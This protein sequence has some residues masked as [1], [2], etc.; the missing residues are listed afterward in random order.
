M[1]LNII[2]IITLQ[3]Q[4]SDFFIMCGECCDVSNW[5]QLLVCIRWVDLKLQAPEEVIGTYV[6]SYIKSNTIVAIIKDTLTRLNLSLKRCRGQC[7]D[8]ASNMNGSR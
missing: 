4:E 3:I 8:G 1:Y 7:C 5:E 6:L 2:R